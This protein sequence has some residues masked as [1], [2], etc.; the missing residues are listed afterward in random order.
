MISRRVTINQVAEKAGVSPTS[1]S[2]AYNNPEQISPATVERILTVAHELGYSPNP[3]ARAMI[4]RRTGVIG[5]LVPFNISATFA[6]PFISHFMEGVGS[7]CDQHSL[8]ALIVSPFEESLE[9]AA[10]RAPVDGYLVLGLDEIHSEIEPLRRRQ[11][12][13]VIVDGDAETVSEINA[14]D[15]GGAYAAA[16]HLLVKGHRDI[17]IVT[18]QPPASSHLDDVYYGVGGR[19]LAGYQGAFNAHDLELRFDWIVPSFTSYEGGA[20]AFSQAWKDGFR[21]TA[22]LALSDAMAIGVVQAAKQL[23]LDV[24]GD[25]EV[26]G[27][28]DIALSRLVYPSLSTVQQPIIEKGRLAAEQLIATLGGNNEIKKIRLPT[29]L[30]LRESTRTSELL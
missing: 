8:N 20:A 13:F 9:E 29:T 24:P 30:V 16:Q 25:L 14:D 11:M 22:V 6:N 7:V 3:I 21:P 19:R 2:F 1:V 10:R 15:E 12:P 4:S 23:G 26:I 5:V 17:L 18:F 27:F 28:D